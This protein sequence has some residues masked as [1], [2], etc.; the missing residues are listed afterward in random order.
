[1]NQPRRTLATTVFLIVLGLTLI[2]ITRDGSGFRPE[3]ISFGVVSGVQR[4]FGAVERSVDGTLRSVGE[5]RRLREEYEI[6]LDEIEAYRRLEGSIE[7]LRAENNRLREQL[8]FA[9]RM[10][11]PSIAAQVIGKESGR[12]FS[13]FT[14]NQGRRN[15]VRRGQAVVAY[16][17]GRQ[18]LVGR[19]HEVSGGTAIVLPVFAA[20]SYVAARMERSRHEGLIE[21]TGQ[22][23]DPLILRYLE[24]QRRNEVQY[25]DLVV[26]SGLESIFPAGL[27]I[28]TVTRVTAPS[29][30]TSL[31]VAVDPVIDFDKLEYVFVLTGGR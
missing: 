3:E 16:I 14:I 4:V 19:I 28:G 31:H 9:S 11:V 6:L 1:M 10:E 2:G 13:S 15:G 29:Y 12:L 30:E 23:D 21:G 22:P 24:R 17:G 20:G 8:G 7:T 25:D 26:T 18:G 5:L 27:P